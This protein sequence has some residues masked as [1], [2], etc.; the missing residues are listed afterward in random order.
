MIITISGKPGSGKSTVARSLARRLDMPHRSAGDFMRRMAVERGISVLGLSAI[1]ESDGGEID[2][3]IDAR[4]RELAETETHF[5]MDS[6]LAWFFI[7]RSVKVFLEV[8]LEVAAARIYGD[9]RGGEMENTNLA[10]TIAAV[11]RRLASETARYH[12][13]YGIDWLDPSHYDLVV[14][15]SDLDADQVAERI[16]DYLDARNPRPSRIS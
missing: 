10:A 2:R 11:E 14:D 8:S 13:Y 9:S 3:E 15:T 7:P 1:A 5:V 6:R 4:T 12:G 16:M